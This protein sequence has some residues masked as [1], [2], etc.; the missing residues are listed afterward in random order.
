MQ[1][2]FITFE[3]CEGAGKSAQMRLLGQYFT[4]NNIPFITTRE[5]GG[6]SVAEKIREVILDI[7]NLSMAYECEVLLYAA[8]RADHIKNKILPAL[9]EGKVVLCDRFIDSSFAYQA[10]ARGLGIEAVKK[11]NFYALENCM[12]HM[13]LFL[14]IS[15]DDAFYRKGGAD[16]RDR[17]EA[18]GLEFH[19][20]VYEGYLKLADMFPER[21]VRIECHGEK[22]KTHENILAAL[23]DRGII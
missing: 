21:F 6:T 5:P 17:M 14:D 16:G 19:R 7:D 11:A 23:R 18:E 1:G 15:P 10:H 20:K 12:P 3:G 8:S 2:K 13:T 22:L 4:Q 9:K